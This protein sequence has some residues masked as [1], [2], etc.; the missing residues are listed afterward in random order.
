[1]EIWY[2][3]SDCNQPKRNGHGE[4][5]GVKNPSPNLWASKWH[6]RDRFFWSNFSVTPPCISSQ[7][8]RPVSSFVSQGCPFLYVLTS[9]TVTTPMGLKSGGL[10]KS[11]V[12]TPQ[13]IGTLPQQTNS[14]KT[15]FFE[16]LIKNLGLLLH[17]PH[18]GV[19]VQSR[20]YGFSLGGSKHL[21]RHSYPTC[22]VLEDAGPI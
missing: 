6:Q 7:L 12:S 8:W 4:G 11:C 3:R 5:P 13:A 21:L 14:P 20:H 22:W 17:S 15:I 2:Q 9:T 18:F 19:C 16:P 1:M 10:A